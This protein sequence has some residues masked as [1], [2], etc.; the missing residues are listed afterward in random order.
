MSV[1]SALPVSNDNVH[2]LL[3]NGNRF[4]FPKHRM[5]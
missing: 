2:D 1:C 3:S 5:W 4:A